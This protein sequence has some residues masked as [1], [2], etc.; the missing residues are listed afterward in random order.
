MR[1]CGDSRRV[2]DALRDEPARRLR[3]ARHGDPRRE[4][5]AIVLVE[6]QAITRTAA[7]AISRSS[8]RVP[9][10]RAFPAASASWTW[11]IAT[12]G[13]SAGTTYT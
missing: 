5:L 6:R 11:R 2:E 12:S 10:M 4:V 3:V 8:K 1:S 13:R 9:A 7:W